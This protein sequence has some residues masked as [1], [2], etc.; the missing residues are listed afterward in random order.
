MKNQRDTSLRIRLAG[1]AI[2]GLF[3]ALAAAAYFSGREVKR[4]SELIVT[5]AVPGTI[6]AH[7]MRMAMSR[8]IGWAMVAASA[9]TTQSRDASLKIVHDAD[10][11]F[12]NAVEQYETTIKINPA[13]DRALLNQVTGQFAEFHRQRMAYEA[14]I[15]A[16][17][18]EGS[19]AFLEGNLVPAYVSAIQ[20]GEELLKHNNANSITY[21]GYI[22]NSVYR[23]YWAVAVVMVLALICAG[24]LFASFS[25]RRREVKKLR[26]SEEKFSKVFQSS[27]IPIAITGLA[28]GLLLDVNESF[29]RMSGFAREEVIGHTTLELNVY[30]DPDKRAIIVEHLHEHGHLHGQEQLFQTKSGQIRN[31]LL[32][33]DM[34][35]ISSKQ[36]LLVIALD[37]T[38]R[39]RAEEVLREKQAQLLFAMD[40]AKLAHWEFDVAKNLVTGDENIFQMH[41]TTSAQEGG[42]S[43]TPEDYIRKF[44]HPLDAALVANEVALGVATTD[45]NFARQFEHR[46]IRKDGTEGVLMVR[47]RIVMDASGR[48]G[49]IHGTSQ[50]ITERKRTED[51]NVR[52]AMAI[53]QAAETI[54]ITDPDG[55]ILYAN[56]AFEKTTGYTRAEALGQN[57]RILK[58]NKHDAEFYR[59]MWKTLEHGE[60]WSG[61]FI[62][63]RKDGMLYEEEAT[64]SPV[65][66]TTGK[67]TNY[68]AVK[69]D[70][71]HEVQLEEQF[72]QSQKMEAVGQ[73]AS[74]VAHDFNNI[75][76][77]IQMQSDLLKA[78]G[79]LSPEQTGFARRLV[80]PRSEPPRL[81]VSCFY[82][83]GREKCRRANWI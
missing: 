10:V 66:D 35:S 52:L 56:P 1:L 77:I 67:V 6:A 81:L 73:L 51:L 54:V 65:R 29:L 33:F 18:R 32:W 41:G 76:A 68:V 75:L 64:I 61:H 27:P 42:L 69:R 4:S 20:S 23:L 8:S 53:E 49:K 17:N 34:I 79:N 28:D 44:V 39:K 2:L 40:I 78:E 30:P 19:A 24:V 59:R 63:R 26:E 70:V 55:T 48:T 22:R 5:D 15:L 21:S 62:N 72:R 31:H 50:D 47:S 25:I 45:P 38:E 71:T 3:I 7:D 9:Q 80:R 83:A 12:T 14:L 13:A 11:A 58:S 57:P 82:S 74:G 60:V 37:I 43:M 36:W 16:G 46:F